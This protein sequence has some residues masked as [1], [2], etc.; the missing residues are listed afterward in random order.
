MLEEILDWWTE[1]LN[2]PDTLG[3]RL[4]YLVLAPLTIIIAVIAVVGA[5]VLDIPVWVVT[6]H[7]ILS[8][9]FDG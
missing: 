3:R 5:F 2:H 6:G 8:E 1:I 7:H 4:C 9:L